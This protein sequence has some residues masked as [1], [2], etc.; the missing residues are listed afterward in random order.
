MGIPVKAFNINDATVYAPNEDI[1]EMMVSSLGWKADIVNGILDNS[2]KAFDDGYYHA[3]T[4]PPSEY[5]QL[6]APR[7]FYSRRLA[8]RLSSALRTA[9][10]T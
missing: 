8:D 9:S 1:A 5:D 10:G 3:I 2:A 6:L 7:E 4:H